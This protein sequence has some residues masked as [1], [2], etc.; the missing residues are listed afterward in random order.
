MKLIKTPLASKNKKHIFENV[1]QAKQ[2][3]KQDKLSQE[4]LKKLIEIDPT[5][6]RKFVGWM[7]KQYIKGNIKDFDELKSIIE[8]FYTLLNKGKTKTKDIYQIKS[9]QDLKDEVDNINDS[10]DA[11]SNKDLEK[12]YEVVKDNDRLLIVSPHTHEASR[13][14]GLSEFSFRECED[15]SKDS[16]WCTTYKAPD[17]FNDYYYSHNVTFYYIKI[18]SEELKSKVVEAFPNHEEAMVVTALAVLENGKIDGYDGND[19]QLSPEKVEK[20]TNLIGIS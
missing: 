17:H 10:G 2:Y 7:A 5:K 15:G 6:T 14:L 9:Y 20:F 12:D 3:V 4:D 16:A 13:K 18:K 8:E 11:V 1:K 19:K